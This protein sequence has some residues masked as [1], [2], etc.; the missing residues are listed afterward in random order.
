MVYHNCHWMIINGWF[1]LGDKINW[2]WNSTSK[3]HAVLLQKGSSSGLL[4]WR[5]WATTTVSPRSAVGSGPR[6][7]I[8]PGQPLLSPRSAVGS[9][10]RYQ[11]LSHVFALHAIITCLC[12]FWLAQRAKTC[13]ACNSCMSVC[14]L[15]C[16]TCK[17]V[18]QNLIPRATA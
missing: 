16:T 11:I 8:R 14:F 1:Q 5:A 9:G 3:V 10:P 15:T 6:Y 7:Q 2:I 18:R 12:V 17:N 13:F 4:Q